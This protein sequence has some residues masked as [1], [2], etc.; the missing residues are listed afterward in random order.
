MALY[1]EQSDLQRKYIYINIERKKNQHKINNDKADQSSFGNRDVFSIRL[2]T[3]V[4]LLSD[5]QEVDSIK[6]GRQQEKNNQLFLRSR[7]EQAS[8]I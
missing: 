4:E 1:K 7:N 3:G 2:K 8:K 5:Q 6:Q